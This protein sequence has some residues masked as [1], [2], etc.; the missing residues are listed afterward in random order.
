MIGTESVWQA[1]VRQRSV[2]PPLAVGMVALLTLA[3]CTSP[4]R[5]DETQ[6]TG[7]AM[8]VSPAAD[9]VFKCITEKGWEVSLS[10]DGG[11]E[12]SSDSVP[13]AQYDQYRADSDAC[14]AVVDDKIR[15]M[16]P[17]QIRAAYTQELAT[18]EC[19]TGLG[20]DVAEPPSEQAFLDDFFIDRWSAYLAAGFGNG[21]LPD[22]EWR[23]VVQSCPQP[24]GGWGVD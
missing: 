6:A 3:A 2:F 5:V 22:D 4:A 10:W 14:W 20:Y 8:S 19:L 23:T 1:R 17:D 15:N 16:S 24:S 7:E 12:A 13:Q 21:S 9:Q 11:I 18:R